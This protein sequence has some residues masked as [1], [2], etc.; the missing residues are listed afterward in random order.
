MSDKRKALGR[1]LGALIPTGPSAGGRPVDVFFRDQD[2]E[3][4][5]RDLGHDPRRPPGKGDRDSKEAKNAKDATG[6]DGRMP[7]P[8]LPDLAPVP[9]ASFAE[10]P[11]GSIRPNPRQPRTVFDDDEMAELEVPYQFISYPGAKHGFTNPEATDKGKKY[12]LPLAYDE[13][14]D[15]QSW[16]DMKTFW[17]R[18]F[19]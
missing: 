15:R 8:D 11:V 12:G 19:R 3:I 10:L 17:Q 7:S 13:K 14:T 18:V 16:E 4:S 5:G 6:A 2:R 1:G 9:G